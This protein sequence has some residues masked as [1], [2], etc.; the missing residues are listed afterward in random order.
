MHNT[1]H[2]RTVCEAVYKTSKKGGAAHQLVCIKIQLCS[3]LIQT[4]VLI[5]TRILQTRH[6]ARS[7]N[8]IFCP[9][10]VFQVQFQIPGYQVHAG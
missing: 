10:F 7:A 2:A 6:Y 4:D 3:V 5:P 1:L 9:S 8:L